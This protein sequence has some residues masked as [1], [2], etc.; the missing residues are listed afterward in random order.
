MQSIVSVN[1]SES[2]YWKELES[3]QLKLLISVMR[4]DKTRKSIKEMIMDELKYATQ[5]EDEVGLFKREWLYLVQKLQDKLEGKRVR[6][7]EEIEHLIKVLS[8]SIKREMA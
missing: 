6:N 1:S 4:T 7:R 8:N 2:I 5:H 3:L